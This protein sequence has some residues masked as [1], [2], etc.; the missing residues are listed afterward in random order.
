MHA[1]RMAKH[2]RMAK[3]TRKPRSHRV[4]L[5]QVIDRFLGERLRTAETTAEQIWAAVGW[6]HGEIGT[7]ELT[8]TPVEWVPMRLTAFETRD[9]YLILLEIAEFHECR[10]TSPEAVA[11]DEIEQEEIADVLDGNRSEETLNLILRKMLD[12]PLLARAATPRAAPAPR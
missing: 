10:F 6:A 8:S 11:V 9:P 12:R 1:D 4:P 5:E 7:H 3:L 2:V